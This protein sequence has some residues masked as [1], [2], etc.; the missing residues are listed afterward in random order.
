M[1]ICWWGSIFRAP[2]AHAVS[3]LTSVAALTETKNYKWGLKHIPTGSP[4][5]FYVLNTSF[6]ADNASSSTFETGAQSVKIYD[7]S[8]NLITDPNGKDVCFTQDGT[9]KIKL[10]LAK[11]GALNVEVDFNGT[12]CP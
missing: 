3:P 8:L 4:Q 10:I 1:G 9:K 11:S 5:V 12:G 6:D 2:R 7:G